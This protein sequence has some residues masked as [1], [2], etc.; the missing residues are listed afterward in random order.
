MKK[1]K[2]TFIRVVTNRAV[3]GRES[4]TTQTKSQRTTENPGQ[5]VTSK[6]S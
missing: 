4:E 3:N 1:A 5:R 6:R 2:V